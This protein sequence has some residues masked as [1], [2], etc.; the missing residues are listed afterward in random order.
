MADGVWATQRHNEAKLNEAF[1]STANVFLIFSVNMSGHFQVRFTRD[2]HWVMRATSR[3]L[4]GTPGISSQRTR[5]WA[6]ASQ[7]FACQ[8]INSASYVVHSV[9]FLSASWLVQGYARMTTTVGGT[10]ARPNGW[11]GNAPVGTLFGIEWRRVLDL[12]FAATEHM[13]NPL[14]EGKPVR[15]ARCDFRTMR[16]LRED[17]E[18][19]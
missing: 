17:D 12:P 9:R 6:V 8:R 4:Q 10:R 2:L 15:I 3:N 14:N 5:S 19:N 7:A 16:Q 1:R 11:L 18:I 13:T